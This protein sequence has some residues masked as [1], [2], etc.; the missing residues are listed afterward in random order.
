MPEIDGLSLLKKLRNFKNVYSIV[1]T[2][3]GCINNLKAAFD[4]GAIDFIKKPFV[5]I[6]LTSRINNIIRTINTEDK[7]RKLAVTDFLTGVYNRKYFI[8]QAKIEILKAKR[9]NNTFSLL[10]FDIDNFKN[11]NDTFGH[12]AGDKV[13]KEFCSLCK[14]SIRGYDYF[15]R[16]GGDEFA[17]TLI[18]SSLEKAED[19]AER[20]KNEVNQLKV[21]YY[22]K[23]IKFTV[24]IG[25]TELSPDKN[26]D[27]YK[28][29]LRADKALY[30]A[31]KSG[32][33]T[34][35]SI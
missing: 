18:N 33:N 17:L 31:K 13:M 34:F 6:E 4:A 15:C 32:R 25:V 26:E 11:I 27:I 19:A 9:C 20:I 8:E 1:I 2:G 5:S 16:F 35:K 21:K 29:L 3:Q 24:S 12:Q 10:V 22:D 28:I 7:L 30:K 14:S 23:I